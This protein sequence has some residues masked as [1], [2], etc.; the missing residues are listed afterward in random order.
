M[1]TS[2]TGYGR[3]R[4]AADGREITIEI[5]SVNSRYFEYSSRMPRAYA[6]LDDKM[7]Q[8]LAGR[9]ARGKVEVALSVINTGVADSVVTVNEA[10]AESYLTALHSIA[11]KLG[12][13][14]DVS[15]VSIAKFP[16][17]LTL[18]KAEE[19]EDAL[20]NSVLSVLAEATDR[21]IAMRAGEG[22]RMTADITSR[23]SFLEESVGKIEATSGER[24]QKYTDRLY[25][26]LK[27]LLEDRAVDES[28]IL[29]EAAIFAD[30]TA[31]D[32]ETVRLRSHIQQYREILAAGGPVGRKLDFLTQELNRETNTIGSKCQELTITRM[33]VDMKAEIE[34]IREQIQNLE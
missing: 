17:V 23:L 5:K 12:V 31:V 8:H 27:T 13:R 18:A 32:E 34:K 6:F 16:D 25:E 26:K 29:T 10:L 24:V 3:A 30:K 15:A 19:D 9:L 20:W 28:R 14:E 1:I 2:M 4:S 11:E 7:K 22:E 33:V 21:F